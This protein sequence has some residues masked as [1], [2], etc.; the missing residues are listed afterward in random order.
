LQPLA[1]LGER[2]RALGAKIGLVQL[3]IK[4]LMQCIKIIKDKRADAQARHA[5][6][7]DAVAAFCDLRRQQILMLDQLE[8]VDWEAPR[9]TP[10]GEKPLKMVVTKT[11]QHTL[12][13]CDTLLRMGLWWRQWEEQI[14]SMQ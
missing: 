14:R 4:D 13:H 9:P 11:Y 7:S 10:W 2:L 3:D 12:E 6:L 1:A 8:Q 5:G